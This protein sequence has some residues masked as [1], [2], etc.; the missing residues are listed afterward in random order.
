[1]EFGKEKKIKEGWK[2]LYRFG[3]LCENMLLKHFKR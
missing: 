3:C 2:V 1:M